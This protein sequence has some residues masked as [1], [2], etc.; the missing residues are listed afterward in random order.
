M[1]GN[2]IK[3]LRLYLQQNRP[4]QAG[5]RF[6]PCACLL[7]S[8]KDTS[9]FTN[10]LLLFV[11]GLFFLGALLAFFLAW[12]GGYLDFKGMEEVKYRV[13]EDYEGHP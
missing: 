6:L 13:L 5:G 7:D 11:G 10:W 2:F 4:P 1:G 9:L 8:V 3:I 12:K